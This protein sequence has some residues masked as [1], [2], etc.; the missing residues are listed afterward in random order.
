[1]SDGPHRSLRMRQSW[2]W[3]AKRCDKHAFTTAEIRETLVPAVQQD[4]RDELPLSAL[5]KVRR[6]AQEPSLFKSDLGQ[7]I[8][9]LKPEC[10]HGIGQALLNNL[11]RL[12]GSDLDAFSTMQ[13]ALAAALKD[14]AHRGAWQVEEHYLRE[15][16]APR[17]RHVRDRLEEAIDSTDFGEIAARFLSVDRQEPSGMPK[18]RTDVDDGVKLK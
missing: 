8:A 12:S 14:R 10:G 17:A 2:R 1:M 6:I 3:V 18:K 9:S 4:C 16:S 7:Q 15:A 5:V 11:E 13:D